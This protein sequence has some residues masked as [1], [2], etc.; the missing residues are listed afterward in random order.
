M[1][2]SL[3]QPELWLTLLAFAVLGLDLLMGRAARGVVGWLAVA[4]LL[5][6]TAF[7]GG[8]LVT[9]SF[10]GG[11]YKADLYTSLFRVLIPLTSAFVG[12]LSMQYVSRRL[13]YAGEYYGLLVI[14]TLA[15]VLMTGASELITAYVSLETLNFC[16]YVLAGYDRTDVRS[17]EAGVKYVILSAFASALLLYGISLLYGLTGVTT[18]S[19]ISSA[20]TAPAVGQDIALFA[21][22]TFIVA[23]LGFKLAAAP[24]HAW[25]P[26]VYQGAPTP[27]TA[28]IAV[29]SKT[30]AFALV[31]RLF[32]EALAPAFYF[33]QPLV[34]VLAVASMVWGNLVAIQQTNVK[35]LLAYSSIS[36]VGYVLV[37]LAALSQDSA[38]AALV[39]LAGYAVT[40][41]AAFACVIAYQNQTGS[42]DFAGYGGMAQRAPVLAFG[43]AV[44]LFS[45]AGMPLFAGFVTKFYLFTAAAAGGL[46]WLVALAV[47]A[48][49]VSLYYYLKVLREAYITAP[50]EETPL[51][52]GFV[53]RSTI[54]VLIILVFAVGLYPYPLVG[55]VN[56]ATEAL[57]FLHF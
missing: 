17:N 15:M 44:S 43:L 30:A 28:L 6:V 41:L 19:G 5:G 48:S 22:L 7:S 33:W 11:L 8:L 53:L 27:V 14:A 45:L 50:A 39:H 26:D 12:L 42:D 13:K 35:R 34:V 52:I 37:A 47:V 31:I 40:N 46:L 4:G 10:A 36:Q 55:I 49:M 23:G 54:V 3:V 25:T 16:L 21:A 32:T 2:L 29:G 1:N 38:T 9:G 51:R 20:L 57:P 56:G 18:F 24:F